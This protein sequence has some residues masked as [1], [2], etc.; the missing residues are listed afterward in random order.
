MAGDS[1]LDLREAALRRL[2]D[3]SH[4]VSLLEAARFLTA[5]LRDDPGPDARLLLRLDSALAFTTSEVAEVE[6][7]PEEG[8]VEIRARCLGLYGASSPLPHYIS[9]ELKERTPR[10]EA[11]RALLDVVHGHLLKR[12]VDGIEELDLPHN[13]INGDQRWRRRVLAALGAVGNT[14]D[15]SYRQLVA[16]APALMHGPGSKF[17]LE[18]ALKTG[19]G[20]LLGDASLSVEELTGGWTELADEQLPKLGTET[21][22]LGVHYFSGRH[23]QH[24]TGGAEIRITGLPNTK[25]ELFSPGGKAYETVTAVA[26][27]AAPSELSLRLLVEVSPRKHPELGHRRLGQDFWFPSGTGLERPL[28]FPINLKTDRRAD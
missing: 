8:L 21:T 5:V 22:R 15:L 17:S 19:L 25:I 1:M 20:S 27:M 3:V 6:D 4:E 16:M 24:P 28:E 23:V 9:E 7:E 11:A 14:Q 13:F 26:V 2:G 18:M 10:A 12:Y